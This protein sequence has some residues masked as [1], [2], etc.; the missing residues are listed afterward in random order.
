MAKAKT[1]PT[2]E[3]MD[4]T[5]A[6]AAEWV[7]KYNTQNRWRTAED[8]GLMAQSMAEGKWKLNG[9]GIC[10]V[11][12]VGQRGCFIQDG[13]GRAQAIAQ[14]GVTVRIMVAQ[15][16]EDAWSTYDQHTRRTAASALINKY[17]E[18]TGATTIASIL[19]TVAQYQREG[20]A[21]VKRNGKVIVSDIEDLYAITDG[22]KEA[23]TIGFQLSREIGGR[24]AA[25]GFAALLL[26]RVDADEAER[27][28][29]Q[30]R[31]GADLPKDSP[32]YALRERI[33]VLNRRE[34]GSGRRAAV[35]SSS[36]TLYGSVC[37]IMVAWNLYQQGVRLGRPPKWDIW[38]DLKLPA[39][40]VNGL[41]SAAA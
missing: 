20:L 26:W 8:I 12:R 41:K 1:E 7:L 37:A 4:V 28:F 24:Q 19:R 30:L 22:L 34:A 18:I 17:S 23:R 3:N 15:G 10:F 27:F 14:S 33:R 5:P 25:Y 9:A 35:A 40:L 38:P 32:I 36:E 2:Y 16:C 11:G 13:G 39:T 6:M 29:N 31:T 21:G